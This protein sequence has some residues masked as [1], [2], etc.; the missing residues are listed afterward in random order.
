MQAASIVQSMNQSRITP[1]SRPPT[2]PY[3]SCSLIY[4]PSLHSCSVWYSGL[5]VRDKSRMGL[6]KRYLAVLYMIKTELTVI[7]NHFWTAAHFLNR[8]LTLQWKTWKSWNIEDSITAQLKWKYLRM[9][10]Q[11]KTK[12]VK[13]TASRIY[14]VIWIN[15]MKGAKNIWCNQMILI[16][17]NMDNTEEWNLDSK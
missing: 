13:L 3:F 16:N 6:P 10:L 7:C 12:K 14:L 11:Y 15:S 9:A 4:F 2:I 17:T 5:C 8:F 1:G